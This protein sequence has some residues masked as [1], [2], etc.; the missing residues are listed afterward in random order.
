MR[1][2]PGID[3]ISD[4]RR[5]RPGSRRCARGPRA[6]ATIG[7]ATHGATPRRRVVAG[8][9]QRHEQRRGIRQRL[10][11]QLPRLPAALAGSSSGRGAGHARRAAAIA[12]GTDGATRVVARQLAP[13]RAA[14]ASRRRTMARLDAPRRLVWRARPTST[15][16][17]AAPR[18]RRTV[19][20]RSPPIR[21]DRAAGDRA[22]EVSVDAP[23][24]ASRSIRWPAIF[25]GAAA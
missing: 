12:P 24:S 11:Q 1:R 18:S 6:V 25:A 13:A 2:E 8:R 21:T 9:E 3:A 5:A 14:S 15:M 17:R 7:V 22:L 20:V 4:P 16:R 23:S 19:R 10:V